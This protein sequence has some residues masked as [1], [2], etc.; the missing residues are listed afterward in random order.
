MPAE[1]WLK[2]VHGAIATKFRPPPRIT[3][4]PTS[5]A[6]GESD[7]NGGG[8]GGGRGKEDGAALARTRSA[9]SETHEYPKGVKLVLILTSLMTSMFLVAL[10]RGFASRGFRISSFSS[11]LGLARAVGTWASV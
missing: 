2:R 10:V 7:G 3:P 5:L 11:A 9:Q 6:A 8:G 4:K 1:S